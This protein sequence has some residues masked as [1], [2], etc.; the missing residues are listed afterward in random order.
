MWPCRTLAVAEKL[1]RSRFSP[2]HKHC[3][4]TVNPGLLACNE[5]R[6]EAI[7]REACEAEARKRFDWAR[8]MRSPGKVFGTA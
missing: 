1:L 2:F 3:R 5:I 4:F 7:T 6:L 8:H